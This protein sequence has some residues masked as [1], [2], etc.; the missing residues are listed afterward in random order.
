MIC[1]QRSQRRRVRRA[2]V[3]DAGR[4]VGERP[5]DDVAVAGDPADVGGAPVHVVGLD[6]EDLLVAVRRADEVARGRVGDALRLRRRAGRV[7]QVEHVLAVERDGRA[8]GGLAV[9]EVVPPDVA[10]LDDGRLRGGVAEPPDHQDVLDGRRLGDRLV[11][12]RLERHRLAAAVA[13]VGGDDELRLGV[14][15]PAATAPR[16]RSRR[17]R[18]CA[19]APIRAQASIAIGSS[20]II[21]M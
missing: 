7:E 21:G 1:H 2:L 9:D 8:V 18:P 14:V 20:G 16:P 12:G 5:V 3:Q 13:A 19:G 4:R 6:V 15:D 17:R 10:A 11:D